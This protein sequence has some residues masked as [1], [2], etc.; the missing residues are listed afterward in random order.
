LKKTKFLFIWL[1]FLLITILSEL[2]NN[3]RLLIPYSISAPF[4]IYFILSSKQLTLIQLKQLLNLFIAVAVF[5]TAISFLQLYEIIPLP[6]RVVGDSF[7]GQVEFI[8]GLDDAAYGTF[9]SSYVLSWFQ[10][11]ISFL[12]FIVWAIN[13]KNK[14]LFFSFLIIIQY[15]TVDS[16]TVL[17]VTLA[18]VLY[19]VLFVIN[20]NAIFRINLQKIFFLLFFL[21][22]ISFSV[23]YGLNNYYNN[24]LSGTEDAKE[25]VT[26]SS[27]IVINKWTEWGKIRGFQYVYDDFI[28]EGNLE[29]IW[30]YGLE[31][32]KYNGKM[33]YIERKDTQL[34]QLNNATRSRSGLI[35]HFAQSGILGFILLFSSIILWYK[36]NLKNN[37]STDVALVL[38]VLLKIF[39]FFSFFVSFLYALDFST[40]VILCFFAIVAILKNYSRLVD[41]K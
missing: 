25:I 8:T 37:T 7:G 35:T 2:S 20:K 1:A 17:A 3:H 40:M 4:L 13:K 34:M 23:S 27:N 24:N 32:Y 21:F 30:G 15:I 12:L 26:K 10:S 38:K 22:L 6:K 28:E 9:N 31:S 41:F 16:K 39:L 5:Q 11:L 18:M 36:Y 19:F 29:V 14:Y 33:G